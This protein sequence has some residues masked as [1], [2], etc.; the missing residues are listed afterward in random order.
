[1]KK[2][3][4]GWYVYTVGECSLEQWQDINDRIKEGYDPALS[5]GKFAMALLRFKEVF[6]ETDLST[7]SIE[8]WI[9]EL[10]GN[11]KNVFV[12]R[13]NPYSVGY[14]VSPVELPWI[15]EHPQ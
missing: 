1:M 6:P 10:P 11:E 7:S 14:I 8:I 12:I 5:I 9:N 15:Q 4:D 2:T 3:L 13:L